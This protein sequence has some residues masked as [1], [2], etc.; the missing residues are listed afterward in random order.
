V[1]I[2]SWLVCLR[3]VSVRVVA[4]TVLGGGVLGFFSCG[5]TSSRARIRSDER[6]TPWVEPGV[7]KVQGL[8]PTCVPALTTALSL[9]VPISVK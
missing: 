6:G 3:Y 4:T 7:A 2:T 1:S 9:L 8:G 5:G